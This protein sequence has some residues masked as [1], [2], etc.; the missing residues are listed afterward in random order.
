[1][2]VRY[3]PTSHGQ[4]HCHYWPCSRLGQPRYHVQRSDSQATTARSASER[5]CSPAVGQPWYGAA[6]RLGQPERSLLHGSFPWIYG[7][8]RSNALWI[9]NAELRSRGNQ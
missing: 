2:S 8:V 9:L 4:I 6:D 5:Q 1:M 3:D 7:I